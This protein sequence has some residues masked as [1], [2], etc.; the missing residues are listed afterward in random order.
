MAKKN[1]AVIFGGKSAEHDVS[2][3]TAHIP[4]IKSLLID[5]G[6]NIFPIYIS[7][8][9]KWYSNQKMNNLDYFKSDSF[10]K[11]LKNEKEIEISLNNEFK[12]IWPGLFS[13]KVNID[14]VFPAMHGT[15]GEDGSLMG[16]LRM[17]NVPFIGCDLS[18]SNAAMDKVF[19]KQI[20]HSEN[21]PIVPYVWF[22]SSDYKKR[23]DE[24]LKKIEELNYPL[25]VKPT[26]LGSSIG[27][28]KVKNNEELEQ[29]IEVA[30]HY[31]DKV[32]VEE[33]IENLIEVT[34]PII[35]NEELKLGEIERP[36]NKTELFDFNEKYLSGGKNEGVNSQYSEIPAKITEELKEKV[37]KLGKKT[38]KALGCSGISRV[39]FLI[40]SKENKVFVNEVNTLPGSLYHHNWKKADLSN[41][42]LVKKL[43]DLAEE[44][45][46]TKKD[47]KYTFKS[48][49]LKK[50]DGNKNRA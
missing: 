17:A 15:Y 39:D 12:I 25:F 20:L 27:I 36:L 7:K 9:G 37:I 45:Y 3:I 35:G 49:I 43:V 11:D 50:A 4:I 14:L 38:Y 33:S 13:K 8:S 32:L 19:T 22:T 30:M 21:I 16:L 34:L 42:E 18:A 5:S 6:F 2:I 23:K 41:L 24:I 10:E 29:A 47:I 26:H 28:A 46:N 48:D 44:R 40:D 31:D 1:I